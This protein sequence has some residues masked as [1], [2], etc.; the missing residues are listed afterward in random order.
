[1]NKN[2]LIYEPL[3]KKNQKLVDPAFVPLKI[4]DNSLSA[5]RELKH[6]VDIYDSGANL[7][8]KYTGL[9]SPKFELKT[10]ISG[11]E[12]IDFVNNKPGADVYIINPVPSLFITPSVNLPC[13]I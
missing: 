13:F 4:K 11:S 10:H 5:W 9:F 8:A 7:K 2:I 12:F 1:M 6:L 3:Y